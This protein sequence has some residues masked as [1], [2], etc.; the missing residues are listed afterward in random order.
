MA[1]PNNYISQFACGYE[2]DVSF[3]S[4]L[5]DYTGDKLLCW[6]PLPAPTAQPVSYKLFNLMSPKIRES[7]TVRHPIDRL[8]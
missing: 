4:F 6:R 7:G 1:N 5:H 3:S 2:R 8:R